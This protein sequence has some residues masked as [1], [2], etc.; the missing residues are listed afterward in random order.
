MAAH[1]KTGILLINLGTPEATSFW[2]M[3]RYLKQFLS[4]PRVIER[5]GPLW[6]LI[7]NGIILMKR[8]KT[9][10]RAY[11]RIWNH[12]RNESPLKTITRAQAEG[13]AEY[14]ASHEGIVVDWAMRYGAPPIAQAVARLSKAGC[15]RLLLAPLYP[16]YAAPTTATALDAAY[17]ALGKLRHEPAIRTLPPYFSHPAYIEALRA[18]I[19]PTLKA[20]KAPPFL[21]LSFHGLPEEFIARGDP[22][23]EQCETTARL[24]G[25]ALGLDADNW[26]LTYQS[27]PGRGRWIGPHLEEVLAEKARAG[28]HSVCVA[29]PGFSADCIETLE[30]IDIRARQTFLENG[31]QSFTYI[32]ALNAGHEG[33]RLLNT[34]VTEQI[35]GWG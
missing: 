35:D 33:L 4:D 13:L 2:P 23:Q 19:A 10:G 16:Q 28:V 29:S 9:S 24:L 18:S 5:R 21:V 26:I 31:G 14:L 1:G 34:L 3:R 6:W 30:E 22:Y 11:D 27:R 32:P 15:T 8:P 7:L 12:D 17:A 20:A 25:K